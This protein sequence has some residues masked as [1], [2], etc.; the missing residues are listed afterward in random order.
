MKSR[1]VRA[2]AAGLYL[3]QNVNTAATMDLAAFEI[4]LAGSRVL[5]TQCQLP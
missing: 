2:A 5:E 3:A 4:G 1:I